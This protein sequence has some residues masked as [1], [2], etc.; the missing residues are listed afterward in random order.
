MF[1]PTAHPWPTR[2]SRS[3]RVTPHRPPVL[4]PC[5]ARLLAMSTCALCNGYSSLNVYPEHERNP[6]SLAPDTRGPPAS[7]PGY[8]HRS[9]RFWVPLCSQIY[10]CV[11]VSY[12]FRWD[13][14][15]PSHTRFSVFSASRSFDSPAL[16]RQGVVYHV[17]VCIANVPFVV[18]SSLSRACPASPCLSRPCACQSGCA[19]LPIV[20]TVKH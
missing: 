9:V 5:A 7:D 11:H 19:I 2:A 6:P 13:Y 18:A 15:C 10:K 4:C 1:P 8:A 3:T 20:P 16:S 14:F 12:S 17:T